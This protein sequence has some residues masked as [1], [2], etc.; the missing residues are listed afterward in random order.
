MPD[1]EVPATLG[2]GDR[3]GLLGR[4]LLVPALVYIVALVGVPFFLAIGLSLA[5]ATVGDPRI[6]HFVGLAN[7][8]SVLH[9]SAF[10]VALRNSVI[11]TLAT[12]L[13]T[14]VLATAESELLARDFRGKWL[15]QILLI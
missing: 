7:F 11:V 15:V 2:V 14:L 10:P 3:E 4:L 12:L 1:G 13:L 9:E 8:A 6:H 5:S